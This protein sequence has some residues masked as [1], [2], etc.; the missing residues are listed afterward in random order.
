MQSDYDYITDCEVKND[1]E[2]VVENTVEEAAET[3]VR[4]AIERTTGEIAE[5]AV[6]TIVN[7]VVDE[8]IERIVE[9]DVNNCD[10]QSTSKQR[11]G[12]RAEGVD[13][14]K[15]PLRFFSPNA[16]LQL[17]IT[18]LPGQRMERRKIGVGEYNYVYDRKMQST[19]AT[20][21]RCE[22]KKICSAAVH[23]LGEHAIASTN[24]HTRMVTTR[25]DGRRRKCDKR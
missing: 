19:G 18:C 24:N 23:V 2:K 20:R 25:S 15:V 22:K 9:V 5:E 17:K 16:P 3:S 6:E 11:G 10:Q 7:E 4:E 1:G 13:G 21:W 14:E 12:V 8:I